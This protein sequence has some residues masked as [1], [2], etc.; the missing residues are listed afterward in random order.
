MPVEFEELR[1]KFSKARDEYVKALND[2]DVALINACQ[3]D[4]R[5]LHDA[6]ECACKELEAKRITYD[7]ITQK[8]NASRRGEKDTP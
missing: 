3:G 4:S 6:Y 7:E 8:L 2:K 1:K 5:E